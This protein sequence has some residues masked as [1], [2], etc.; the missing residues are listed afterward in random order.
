[1]LQSHQG[2]RLG[3]SHRCFLRSAFVV[4]GLALG[5]TVLAA[6][7]L[8]ITNWV[9]FARTVR[10]DAD[11]VRVSVCRRGS[12][13]GRRRAGVPAG[14]AT[15][16]SMVSDGRTQILTNNWW[17]AG[18]PGLASTLAV[19]GVNFFGD[20]LRDVLDPRLRRG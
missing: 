19:L 6:L 15:W 13:R 9:I 4:G 5:G 17:V 12:I 16:G 1:M 2:D 7:V 8:A 11:L 18:F 10:L 3:L 20:G 14:V